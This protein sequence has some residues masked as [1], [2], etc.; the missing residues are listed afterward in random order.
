MRLIGKKLF[1]LL[2]CSLFVLFQTED[3]WAYLDPSTGS[4]L[5]Q[6]VIAALL[7]GLFVLK[8]YGK[9]VAQKIR[10]IFGKENDN[11]QDDV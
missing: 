7:S 9:N 11:V 3:V 6:I 8:T 4:Y 10:R 1:W 2:V 5:F